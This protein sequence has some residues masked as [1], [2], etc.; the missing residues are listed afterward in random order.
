MSDYFLRKASDLAADERLL[1]ER[2]LGRSLAGDETISVNAYRAHSV[3]PVEEREV[4]Q[5][6]IA[7]PEKKKFTEKQGQYLAFIYHYYKKLNRRAP[8]EADLERYFRVSPPRFT[9]W[10]C[11]WKLAAS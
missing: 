4:L 2:W 10:C 8:A 6:Q 3:P 5:R 9:T 1:I 11:G 7:A